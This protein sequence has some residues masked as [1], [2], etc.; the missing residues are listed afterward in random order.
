M[1]RLFFLLPLL[2][3][4]PHS[5]LCHESAATRAEIGI[6]EKL[7][8]YIPADAV[9]VNENDNS[10]NLRN[11]ID[12]PT[13]I[14]PVYFSCMHVCPMLLNGV[15]DVLGKMDNMKPGKD[16]QVIA[17]SFDDKDSPAIAR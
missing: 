15:S 13:I 6:D 9:F 11:M 1:R 10:V 4:L 2:L 16:F 5:S 8:Q 3:L 17:L 7:G 14:A 12:K